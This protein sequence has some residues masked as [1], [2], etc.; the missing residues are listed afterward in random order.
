[1]YTAIN[2]NLVHNLMY[3]YQSMLY[4]VYRPKHYSLMHY[5]DYMNY[6]ANELHS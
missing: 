4:N 5:N 1:M 2:V 6:I 3:A